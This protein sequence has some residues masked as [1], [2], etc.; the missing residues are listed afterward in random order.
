MF[1]IYFIFKSFKTIHSNIQNN[2]FIHSNHSFKSFK[3]TFTFKSFIHSNHS[4]NHSNIQINIFFTFM[5]ISHSNQHL[6]SHPYSNQ[7]IFHIHDNFIFKS[8]SNIQIN[9]LFIFKSTF[10]NIHLFFNSFI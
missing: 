8:Y 1:H 2:S 10:I 9:I 4:F 6:Y 5:I 7:H 3:T